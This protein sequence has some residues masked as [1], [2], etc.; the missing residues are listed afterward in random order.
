VTA[1]APSVLARPSTPKRGAR[2][3]VTLVAL[4][5]V[6]AGALAYAAST[7]HVFSATADEPLHITAGL[8]WLDGSYRLSDAQAG[9]RPSPARVAIVVDPPLSRVAAAAGPYYA[10]GLRSAWRSESAWSP[11]STAGPRD[12]L[13]GGAG[14]AANLAS[15]R[16]GILP[17]LALVVALTWALA[18]RLFGEAAGLC[19][20]AAVASVPAVLGHAGLATT[21]VAFAA[22]FLL[23]TLAFL[24]CLDL[25]AGARSPRWAR[26]VMLGLAFGLGLATK[27]ST[28]MLLPGAI[29]VAF[30]RDRD[31]ETLRGEP[32]SIARS[33]ATLVSP[34]RHLA[35]V[36]GLAALVLWAAYRFSW[37]RPSV[38]A[39]PELFASLVDRCVAPGA[40][41][42]ALVWGLGL[43]L[44]A[45]GLFEGL[46]VLCGQNGGGDATSYLLG[47]INQQGFPL[48]FPVALA[49]KT[50]LP[51]LALAG[52]GV[53]AAL[54]KRDQPQWRTLAPLMIALVGLIVVLPLRINVGVRHVMHLYPLLAVYAGAGAVALWNAVRARRAARAAAIGLCAW[55]LSTP[56]R[57]APD[58][59]AWFNALAGR[60]PEDVLLDSDLDWGQDLLR[61]EHVLAGRKVPRLSLAYFGASDLCRHHLPPGRWL[62]PYERATGV[63]AIS[64]MYR[65]G[66]V[67]FYYS[68]GN[69]CDRAQLVNEAPPDPRQFEWLDAFTPVARVGASIL[70][71]DIPGP[72]AP[73]GQ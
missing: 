26:T 8:E 27:L 47:R 55:L 66:V 21:D 46:L 37:G 53:A 33:L 67:G 7:H 17:F 11:T 63:I 57:A 62:R 70:L 48:F 60:H 42:D 31:P 13:Y 38:A 1:T 56:A 32:R 6:V 69:F 14:Y 25:E 54:R 20:A 15:A 44:P 39:G 29:S 45:P 43:D 23:V 22:M 36:A 24:S 61:L 50:P 9:S 58:H 35:V 30:L 73:S 2:V 51:F 4:A 49:V 65:K 34:W 19:A 52:V 64:Q 18:R 16:R 28:L 3:L 10:Q 40:R 12:V 5:L 41:R 72:G 68:D 71:Y 59:M